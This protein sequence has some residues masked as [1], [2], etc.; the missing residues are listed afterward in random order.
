ME[1]HEEITNMH[2]IC[3]DI[4][5]GFK[6]YIKASK[7][8]LKKK[9]MLNRNQCTNLCKKIENVTKFFDHLMTCTNDKLEFGF[10]L[11]ELFFI[12]NKSYSLVKK[13]GKPNWFEE[14]IFQSNNKETFRELILDLKCCCDIASN[15]LLKHY[16][17]KFEDIMFATFSIAT[18]QEVEDDVIF[19][20]E[21]LIH[22]SKEEDF[23]YHALIKHLL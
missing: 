23:E 15:M 5:K 14:A 10:L 7:V 21:R 17:N 8:L 16:P 12:L 3:G 4:W 13:C 6:I 22:V 2:G 9:N 1:Q 18:C 19:K 20:H 11:S